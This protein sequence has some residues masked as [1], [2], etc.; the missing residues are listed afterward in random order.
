MSPYIHMPGFG[1]RANDTCAACPPDGVHVESAVIVRARR[2]E[3]RL[4]NF[5]RKSDR[6]EGDALRLRRVASGELDRHER[7]HRMADDC[8]LWDLGFFQHRAKPVGHFLDRG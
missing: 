3:I 1:L 5:H 6:A 8:S 2:L 4:R 7:A